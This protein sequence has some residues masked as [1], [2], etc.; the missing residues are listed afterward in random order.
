MKLMDSFKHMFSHRGA[1]AEVALAAASAQAAV[2][3]AVAS[4]EQALPADFVERTQL[5]ALKRSREQ[6]K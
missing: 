1:N 3:K 5:G 4:V 6:A 2:D